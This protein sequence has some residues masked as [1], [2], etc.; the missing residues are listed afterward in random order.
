MRS[1]RP[2]AFGMLSL[3]LF[4]SAFPETGVQQTEPNGAFIIP[5][6]PFSLLERNGSGATVS[7]TGKVKTPEGRPIKDAAI[8]LKDAETN[9]VVRSTYS[10]SF[11]YYRLEQI[12]TGKSYVLSVNHRRYL[13]AFA[14]QLLEI[15]E[16][17]SGVDFTGE[18]DSD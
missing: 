15:N 4:A 9:Q 10:S 18:S 5:Q 8:V 17:R 12:E 11:G 13:F 2:F 14:A 16:E 7:I 6:K 3:S 1:L